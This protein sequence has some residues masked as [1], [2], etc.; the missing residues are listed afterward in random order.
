MGAEDAEV[1]RRQAGA[2]GDEGLIAQDHLAP[3]PPIQPHPQPGVRRL[4]LAITLA[5]HTGRRREGRPWS[6]G[7][8]VY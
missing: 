8:A 1:A 5:H 7:N 2:A 6:G 4:P 3:A